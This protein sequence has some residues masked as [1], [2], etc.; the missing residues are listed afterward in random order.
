MRGKIVPDS[1]KHLQYEIR[2]VVEDA[3]K[4]V[5]LGVKMQWE[6]I[7][8]PIG[9]GE[10]VAPWIREAIA[11]IAAENSSWAYSPTRGVKA[12]R[13]FIAHTVNARGGVQITADDILF[14]NGLGDA[15]NKVYQLIR[16]EARVIMPSPCYSTHLSSEIMRGDHAPLTFRLDHRNDWQPDLADLR[17]KIAQHPEIVAIMLIN[18]DNP[19]GMTYDREMLEEIVS[20]ARDNGLF[21]ISDEV[22]QQITFNGAQPL[23]IADVLGDVPGLALRGIS[24]EYPWPGGRCGWLEFYNTGK[25][26]DFALY[27]DSL[28]KAKM[29]EVCATTLPQLSIPV[30]MGDSRYQENLDKR[31]KIFEKRANDAYD[32]FNAIDGVTANRPRGAFYFTV[33]FDDGVLRENTLPIADPKVRDFIEAKVPG[34]ISDKRFVYYLM[35]AYGICVTPLSGFHT[36]LRGFRIT[37]LQNDDATR[38][39]NLEKMKQ[40]IE[41]YLA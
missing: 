35:G 4:L 10:Q 29:M 11:N 15:V 14:F 36:E 25:D 8:D 30:V 24:K 34:M 19:T 16:P 9:T 40:A 1:V 17:K 21:V 32:F 28:F 6:N 5:D 22:Y 7:G 27:A 3:Y 31:A 23:P 26:A 12:A 41:A 2:K 13:D 38:L 18:P 20:I 39:A 33:V 37:L